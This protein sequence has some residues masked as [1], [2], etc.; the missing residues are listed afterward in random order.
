[1]GQQR[2]VAVPVWRR[3]GW[4]R[5]RVD[6][7]AADVRLWIGSGCWIQVEAVWRHTVRLMLV[8]LVLLLMLG[9]LVSAEVV[10]L[11]LVL[12]LLLL[13]LSIAVLLV[14]L[15]V[16]VLSTTRRHI[17][18]G[19]DWVGSGHRR[20][21]GGRGGRMEQMEVALLLLSTISVPVPLLLSTL[22][23][24][25]LRLLVLRSFFEAVP[26]ALLAPVA[27]GRPLVEGLLVG[28][29]ERRVQCR[30]VQLL[31]RVKELPQALQ[32]RRE[33][34]GR[35]RGRNRGRRLR[36]IQLHG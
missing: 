12:V 17:V 32:R 23:F 36:G 22:S 25:V 11:L 31:Q 9:R 2:I 8:L 24:A 3:K 15:A 16:S 10:L 19:V 7:L 26:E 6:V 27:L 33:R 35:R 28:H 1:M 29:G 14:A 4:L 34:V 30:H 18:R 21:G 13:L 5:H 20:C